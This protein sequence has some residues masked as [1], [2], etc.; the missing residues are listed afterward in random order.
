MAPDS[1]CGMAVNEATVAETAGFQCQPYYFCRKGQRMEFGDEPAKHILAKP[2]AA[3][4]MATG[5][6]R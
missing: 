3:D 4:R 1:V 5:A 6:R 2:E